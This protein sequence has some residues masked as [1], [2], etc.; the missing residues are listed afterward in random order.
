[1][2]CQTLFEAGKVSDTFPRVMRRKLIDAATWAVV[3]IIVVPVSVQGATQ[4]DAL[5]GATQPAPANS[6]RYTSSDGA[7]R[8]VL[9]EG[10]RTLGEKELQGVARPEQSA[11]F[12]LPV[13]SPHP[14]QLNIRWK[15]LPFIPRDYELTNGELTD[16]DRAK[17]RG[18]ISE[19]QEVLMEQPARVGSCPGH[20]LLLGDEHRGS[21]LA[22]QKLTFFCQDV[23]FVFDVSFLPSDHDIAV[24]AAQTALDTFEFLGA[25]Q[26]P[27]VSTEGAFQIVPPPG[28]VIFDWKDAQP[29]NNRVVEFHAAKAPFEFDDLGQYRFPFLRI[30]WYEQRVG[31]LDSEELKSAAHFTLH[32]G[33]QLV[34]QGPRRVGRAEGYEWVV[35]EKE[36]E[37]LDK[38]KQIV[39]A[40]GRVFLARFRG[41]RD[42]YGRLLST[43]ERSLKTFKIIPPR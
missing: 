27:Y 5:V 30:Q 40:D 6:E 32:E 15:R 13:E 18:R 14:P 22:R 17:I 43:A 2:R 39:W 20:L 4:A 29:P 19:G 42:R 1:M 7:F 36:A 12:A 41:S 26:V 10:W 31:S 37:R 25:E 28:W 24:S 35:E 11:W 38:W 33:A 8:I 23:L 21:R 16:A 3:G 34:E 9:P